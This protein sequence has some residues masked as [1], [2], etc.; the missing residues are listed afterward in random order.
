MMISAANA[1]LEIAEDQVREEFAFDAPAPGRKPLRGEPVSIP[2]GGLAVGS[3]DASNTVDNPAPD[4][5]GPVATVNP[6][7]P[8]NEDK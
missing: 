6:Q 8:S 3:L 7:P 2:Q 5:P 4:E 1:G